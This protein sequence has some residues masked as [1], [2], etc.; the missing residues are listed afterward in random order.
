MEWQLGWWTWGVWAWCI[1]CLS[2]SLSPLGSIYLATL[3]CRAQVTRVMVMCIWYRTY[4]SSTIRLLKR[5]YVCF[6]GLFINVSHTRCAQNKKLVLIVFPDFL[7]KLL[8][9]R[10][11][12]SEASPFIPKEL[13]CNEASPKSPT[14]HIGKS[15][16][17]PTLLGSRWSFFVGQTISYYDYIWVFPK[18]GV[19]Q[20]GWFIMENPIKMD[21]LGVPLFS[22]TLI[23]IYIYTTIYPNIFRL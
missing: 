21:D 9:E 1:T 22:E 5:F 12:W 3:I 4:G 18:I 2:K 10:G 19:P 6:N 15:H 7:V 13:A 23:Y 17:F 11:T 20:N 14:W 16:I 8:V